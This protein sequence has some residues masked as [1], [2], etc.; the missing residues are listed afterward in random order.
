MFEKVMSMKISVYIGT[1]LDGFIAR[2]NGELDWLPGSDEGSDGQDYGFGAF[3]NS[4]DS[5]VMGRN[6]F[7]MVISFGK[8]PYGNKRVIVLSSNQVRIPEHL[9]ETVESRSS[10]PREIF[11]ELDM[12]GAKHVYVDGGKTIQGFIDV[13]LIDEITITRVPILIGDGIPLFGIL[14]N[15]KKLRHLETRSFENGFV[16]SK[17]AI[18]K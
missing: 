4:V 11:E 12:S 7:E 13:G 1:S 15:D 10:S 3:F 5:M 16:Q 14:D 2:K 6:T 17:Y 18:I 9:Q 8:W